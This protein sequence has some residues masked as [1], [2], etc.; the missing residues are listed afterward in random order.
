MGVLFVKI[1]KKGPV[2]ADVRRVGNTR[3]EPACRVLRENV[4]RALNVFRR[5][6]PSKVRFAQI[7]LPRRE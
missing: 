5:P 2:A 4:L 3:L 6:L 7:S 1:R